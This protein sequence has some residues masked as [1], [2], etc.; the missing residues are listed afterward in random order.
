MSGNKGKTA[1]PVRT[2]GLEEL[3][4]IR[5]EVRK[6]KEELEDLRSRLESRKQE[7]D[8]LEKTQLQQQV[9][10][11]RREQD[12]MKKEAR[13]SPVFRGLWSRSL[14]PSARNCRR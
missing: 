4:Q 3:N 12:L 11:N 8:V 9:E 2:A 13:P 1:D 10:L 14:K 6:E 7:I 5:D